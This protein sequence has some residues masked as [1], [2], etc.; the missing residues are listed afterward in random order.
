MFDMRSPKVI[1]SETR[2]SAVHPICGIRP[3][4]TPSEALYIRDEKDELSAQQYH[5]LN[6][7]RVDA[8]EIKSIPRLSHSIDNLER[9]SMPHLPRSTCPR[10]SRC[11]ILDHSLL[12]LPTYKVRGIE[13]VH[14]PHEIG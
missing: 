10:T 6:S 5:I 12:R 14:L 13:N 2:L 1:I 4:R 8:N 9:D 3:N 11:M 7:T